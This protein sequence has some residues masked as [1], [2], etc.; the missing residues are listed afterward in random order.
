MSGDWHERT[1]SV[2][3]HPRVQGLG[4][5]PL[6][7]LRV[8][9][10]ARDL[11][12]WLAGAPRDA[13]APLA[14]VVTAVGGRTLRDTRAICA[15][16][17]LLAVEAAA[18]ATAALWPLL[19]DPDEQEPPEEGSE[20]APD[21]RA[22]LD[23][24]ADG[25]DEDDPDLE[26]LAAALAGADDPGAEVAERLDEVG[27]EA[28]SGARDG[29]A[30]ARALEALV[31][32][33][34]W[35][36]APGA[37]HASLLGRL[38]RFGELLQRLPELRRIAE[39]LG[40]AE[41]DAV[42]SSDELGGSEEVTGVHLSGELTGALPAELALLA[43]ATTE[44]LFYLRLAEQRLV[45]LEL[46]GRGLSGVASPDT[47]GPVLACIDTSGSMAGASEVLAKALVLAVA[48]RVIPQGRAMHLLLFGARGEHAELRLKRGRGGLEGLLDFL[49]LAFEGGTDFDTPLGRALELLDERELEKADVLVVTDGYARAA[50]TIVRAVDDARARRGV[51]VFSVVVGAGDVRGVEPFSDTVWTLGDDGAGAAGLLKVLR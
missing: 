35:G 7:Q 20:E 16:L 37:L 44:D 21:A 17:P 5:D 40:R 18:R 23:A 32:G 41:A 12:A 28:W 25:A 43:D 50:P 6:E 11:A 47:R 33:L 42:R 29:E 31:P 2:A 14:R 22:A 19:R 13:L 49:A 8:E 10:F 27:A 9:A 24:L 1:A 48:R 39:Q 15:D 34:G 4:R 51:R 3:L 30:L 46:A 26:A 38:D 45:S 36:A